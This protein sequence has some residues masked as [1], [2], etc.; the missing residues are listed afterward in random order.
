MTGIERLKILSHGSK[1]KGLLKVIAYLETRPDM[2]EKYLNEEKTP[3]QM[4]EYIRKKAQQQSIS[5]CAAID[6]DVVYVWAISYFLA[7]NEALGLNKTSSSTPSSTTKSKSKKPDK[8]AEI[9][10]EQK[11]QNEKEE[12]EQSQ[13]SIFQEVN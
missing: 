2:D 1:I 6:D 3:D 7:T 5:G 9:K 8:K 13:I 11:E 12:K 10:E 4:W